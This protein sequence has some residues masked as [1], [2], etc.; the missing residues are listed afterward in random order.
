[1]SKFLSLFAI[2]FSLA[3]GGEEPPAA[4]ALEAKPPVEPVTLTVYSGRGESMVG[5]LFERLP[6]DAPFKLDV[7]YGKTACL[8]FS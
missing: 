3:C 4:Q 6:K 5:P 2:C 8:H 1:M 7:Q